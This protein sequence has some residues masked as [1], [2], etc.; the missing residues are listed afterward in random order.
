[1]DC[2]KTTGEGVPYTGEERGKGERADKA[3]VNRRGKEARYEILRRSS[4]AW[5]AGE[6]DGGVKPLR[7]GRWDRGGGG[8]RGGEGWAGMNAG[9]DE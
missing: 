6:K 7:Q 5:P 1:M 4:T 8:R 3:K 2:A 9:V